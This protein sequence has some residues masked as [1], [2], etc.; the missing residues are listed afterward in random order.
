MTPFV[1]D[2][3]ATALTPERWPTFALVTARIG[4]LMLTAPGWS[5]TSLPRLVRTALTVV[6]AALLLPCAPVAKLPDQV[7]DIPLPMAAE[8][9]IGLI[10]GMVAAVLVQAVSLAGEVMS[11]QMGL[12]IAPS[13]SP[14]PEL[15]VSGIGPLTSMLA[16]LLYFMI[17]GHLVLLRGLADSLQTLP[18][19]GGIAFG[20]G[21]TAS[22]ALAGKIFSYA[23]SAAAPVMVALLLTNVALG[24]LSRAVPQ[25]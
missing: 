25:L 23:V 22:I 17:G 20:A 14:I 2:F 11:M 24:I 5:G 12:S 7:L 8:M 19:G 13:Y 1:P 18:P 3:L 9:A 15:Q 21:E 6:L 16:L 4:G 10:I